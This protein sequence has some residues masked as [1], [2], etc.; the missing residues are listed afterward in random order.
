MALYLFLF[1]FNLW[2]STRVKD[3]ARI[4]LTMVLIGGY[5]RLWDFGI[6]SS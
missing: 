4:G 2:I 6:E 3:V 1:P 5:G